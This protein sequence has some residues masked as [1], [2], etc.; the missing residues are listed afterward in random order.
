MAIIH[1]KKEQFDKLHCNTL[2]DQEKKLLLGHC[3]TCD[4][5]AEA[6]AESFVQLPLM[7]APKRMQYE[8]LQK[9]QKSD[10]ELLTKVKKTSKELQLFYYSLKVGLAVAVACMMLLLINTTPVH[11]V[12]AVT[13]SRYKIEKINETIY[14]QKLKLNSKLNQLTSN[15]EKMEDRKDDKKEK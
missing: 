13:S 10:Q 8:I 2:T 7:K 6:L 15:Q 5:C 9:A 12:P 14:H 3:G 11:V 1:I 4:T